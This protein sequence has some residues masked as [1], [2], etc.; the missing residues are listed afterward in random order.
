MLATIKR[1][2]P[3]AEKV[4]DLTPK[5]EKISEQELAKLQA[6]IKTIDQLTVDV[7]RIEIQKYAVMK[8]ME[9][10]QA[11]I[12]TLRK[13]FLASYGTDNVNIQT[14]EIAYAEETQENGQADS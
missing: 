7:G 12:E 4:I 9:K 14:G 1:K 8:A 5:P 13:D 2:T 10:V 6:T 11:E 3:K